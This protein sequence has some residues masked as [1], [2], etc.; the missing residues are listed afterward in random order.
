[1]V[2]LMKSTNV[3]TQFD[4]SSLPVIGF[5]ETLMTCGEEGGLVYTVVNN[6]KQRA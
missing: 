6:G 4:I 3:Q 5:P 1:M 2:N